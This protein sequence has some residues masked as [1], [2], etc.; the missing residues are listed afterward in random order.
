M[1]RA[2]IVC[3]VVYTMIFGLSFANCVRNDG[4]MMSALPAIVASEPWFSVFGSLMGDKMSYP[5]KINEEIDD[6]CFSKLGCLILALSG[7]INATVLFVIVT[8]FKSR[9]R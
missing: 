8:R 2:A 4:D 6:D 7:L 5:E 1:R 9:F 3:L